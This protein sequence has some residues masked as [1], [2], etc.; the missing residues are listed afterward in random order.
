M[1]KVWSG[2]IVYMYF[3]EANKFGEFAYVVTTLF[4]EY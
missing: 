1:T 2:G 3:Q 4:P